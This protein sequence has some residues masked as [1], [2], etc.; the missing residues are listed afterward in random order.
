MPISRRSKCL[1]WSTIGVLVIGGAWFV[2]GIYR[3][4]H[5]FLSE[6]RICGAFYPVVTAIEEFHEATGSLPTNLVQLIPRYLTQ[7]PVAPLAE[8]INY[9]VL[10]DGTNW[11]LR[12]RSRITGAP[13][14]FVQRS[15]QQFTAAEEGE[16][17]AAFHGWRAF[18]E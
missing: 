7:L 14:V 13:R 10:A 12:V 9:R 15:S 5:Q 18:N 2:R 8:S 1:I 17:A 3:S 6:D 4:W 16:A 11:E